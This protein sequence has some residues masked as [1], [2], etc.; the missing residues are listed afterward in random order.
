MRS[1]R[2]SFRPFLHLCQI[3]VFCRIWYV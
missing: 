1:G 3:C 2:S